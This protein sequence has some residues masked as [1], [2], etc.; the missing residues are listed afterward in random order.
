[1]KQLSIITTVIL[2]ALL[3]TF[4]LVAQ[5]KKDMMSKQ[6]MTKADVWTGYLV[7]KM[8]GSGFVKKDAE[9]AM[10]KAMKHTKSCA[11]EES[12]MESGYGLIIG[13]KYIKF[14]EAGDKMAVDYL[15]KST[16]KDN[17]FVE[18]TGTKDGDIVKVKSIADA[19]SEMMEKKMEKKK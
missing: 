18:V 1:M 4:S 5:E 19:K 14:D 17:F 11:L 7:D 15:N 16:K 6:E 10:S 8:C 2:A 12:C 3:A 9:T 13:G